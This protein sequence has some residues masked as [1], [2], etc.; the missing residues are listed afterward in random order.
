VFH[1]IRK[2]FPRYRM[3]ILRNIEEQEGGC[4]KWVG[5]KTRSRSGAYY[6]RVTIRGMDPWPRPEYAH[7]I[8][9]IAFKERDIPLDRQVD[10]TCNNTLCVNP[11]HLQLLTRSR[12]SKV[13]H[14]RAVARKR[15]AASSTTRP[16]RTP[17]TT[18]PR[19]SP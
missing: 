7:R 11:A 6:G 14:K 4:W 8:S 18:Q 19:T 1:K 2:N 5:R 16:P 3:R 9:F 15:A 17:A 13:T 12:H 10:H